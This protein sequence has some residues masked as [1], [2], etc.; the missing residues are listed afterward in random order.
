MK[1]LVTVDTYD[2]EQLHYLGFKDIFRRPSF[3]AQIYIPGF[4]S[5]PWALLCRAG[6]P[7]RT[8]EPVPARLTRRCILKRRARPERRLRAA[9]ATYSDN[10][11]G[12]LMIICCI[13]LPHGWQIR[14]LMRRS[15][16]LKQED[17]QAIREFFVEGDDVFLIRS[18]AGP[19]PVTD[20]SRRL[21]SGTLGPATVMRI[22][23]DSASTQHHSL[24]G[25]MPIEVGW[26]LASCG[27]K[28][29]RAE[30]VPNFTPK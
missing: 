28:A 22:H 1:G 21:H 13:H 20:M 12:R 29:A 19:G 5:H 10:I 7:T 8:D 16:D 4:L 24:A 9:P 25:M 2:Y 18:L 26:N 6:Q 15:T 14:N 23:C 3:P 27:I 11:S 30:A 17:Y